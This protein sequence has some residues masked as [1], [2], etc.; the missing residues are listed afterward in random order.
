MNLVTRELV[1]LLGV[2]GTW[3]PTFGCSAG[4]NAQSG[5]AAA[6]YPIKI[7]C[8][9]GMVADVV[10]EIGGPH[11]AVT[12][13]MG[14]GVDPHLY[15]ATTDD[16]TALSSA[17]M[18]IYSGLMLEGKMTDLFVRIGRS[19]PVYA[20]TERIDEKKDLLEPEDF[21]GHSDPHVWMDV[22]WWAKCAG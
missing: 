17:D 5:T 15:K 3:L 18:V 6:N 16:V 14:P 10:R 7:T 22:S 20:I 19:K 2:L 1:F 12:Q 4:S 9:V 8:T 21:E 13:L 11:V